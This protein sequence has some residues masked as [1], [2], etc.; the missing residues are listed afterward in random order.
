MKDSTENIP[1]LD[2]IKTCCYKSDPPCLK[3]LCFHEI[4]E[5]KQPMRN[6]STG[7][8]HTHPVQNITE[9]LHRLQTTDQSNTCCQEAAHR[10]GVTEK[11]DDK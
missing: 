9:N 8:L 6:N 7:F 5:G 2:L 11:R 3:L 1:Q 4:A 10:G